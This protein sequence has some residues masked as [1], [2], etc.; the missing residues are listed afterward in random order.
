VYHGL[1]TSP[2]LWAAIGALG[3]GLALGQILRWVFDPHA[4]WREGAGAAASGAEGRRITRAIVFASLGILAASALVILPPKSS[5]HGP[6]LWAWAGGFAACGTFAG[7][8]PRLG[9]A[10]SL[11]LL[12]LLTGLARFGR[13]GWQ[14]LELNTELARIVPL[15]SPAS[16][17]T[18]GAY[19]AEYRERGGSARILTLR[20]SQVALIVDSVELDG[21]AAFLAALPRAAESLRLYRIYGISGDSGPPPLHAEGRTLFELLAR[22]GPG[23]G[24][25]PG[26]APVSHSALGGLLRMGR[27]TSAPVPA[28]SLQPLVYGIGEDLSPRLLQTGGDALGVLVR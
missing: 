5:L 4:S 27:A 14:P 24:L 7:I 11:A 18:A 8:M 25:V 12:V 22:S 6:G 9:G 13:S 10:V 3:F 23:E 15:E 21:P 28:E 20:A 16:G 17:P 19:R 1:E 2:Y 26:A